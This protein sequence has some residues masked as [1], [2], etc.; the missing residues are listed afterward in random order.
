MADNV[1][2][3]DILA[4]VAK[5]V[6]ELF[7]GA[8]E[9]IKSAVHD[10]G[11]VVEKLWNAYGRFA[12]MMKDFEKMNLT[13]RTKDLL[14]TAEQFQA[15]LGNVLTTAE[16][17]QAIYDRLKPK[18]QETEK[19]ISQLTYAAEQAKRD[20]GIEVQAIKGLPEQLK[21][22]VQEAVNAVV[23][24]LAG[25]VQSIKARIEEQITKLVG[26]VAAIIEKIRSAASPMEKVK[27]TLRRYNPFVP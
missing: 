12:Q 17:I 11:D 20:I 25:V 19:T 22:D 9:G 5:A 23:R 26:A 18:L 15:R 27:K 3:Q 7:G 1:T 24:E 21:K 4:E 13:G 16:E 8:G 10:L 14:T 2:R 6:G